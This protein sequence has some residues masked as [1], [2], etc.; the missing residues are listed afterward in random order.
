MKIKVQ[1]RKLEDE[2]VYEKITLVYLFITMN[3]DEKLT[4][5]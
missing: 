5:I 3:Y 2:I 1:I 4:D